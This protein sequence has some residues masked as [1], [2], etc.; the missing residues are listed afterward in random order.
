MSDIRIPRGL[1]W[2]VAAG[3]LAALVLFGMI[4]GGLVVTRVMTMRGMGWDQ[5]ATTLEGLIVGGGVG[6]V[7]GLLAVWALGTHGRLAVAALA[8]VGCVAALGYMWA[9]PP[10]VRRASVVAAPVPVPPVASFTFELSAADGLGGPPE[11]GRRLPWEFLRIASNST[12][13]YV[14]VG[15]PGERCWANGVLGGP[16]GITALTELRS[17]LAGL[18]EQIACNDPCP[19]C[20]EVGLQWFLDDQRRTAFITD[21]CWRSLEPLQPIRVSVERLFSRYGAGAACN[22]TS[23]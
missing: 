3:A 1:A 9:V 19:T 18:P 5:L 4:A 13:D 15:R 8:L 20:M 11:D 2:L 10:K 12:L 6:L 16:E 22:R 7:A 14:P 23:P 21:R 17:L